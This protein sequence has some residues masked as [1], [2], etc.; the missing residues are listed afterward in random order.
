MAGEMRYAIVR[1]PI[2]VFINI[3]VNEEFQ[4]TL[5]VRIHPSQI[6]SWGILSFFTSINILLVS[7]VRPVGR[8]VDVRTQSVSSGSRS[9][10]LCTA[11]G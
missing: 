1:D 3:E 8:Q 5:P 2:Y 10:L 6:G 9:G 11:P 7:G 4:L